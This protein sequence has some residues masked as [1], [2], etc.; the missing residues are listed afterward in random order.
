MSFRRRSTGAVGDEEDYDEDRANDEQQRKPPRRRPSSSFRRASDEDFSN[1]FTLSDAIDSFKLSDATRK[2]IEQM[3]EVAVQNAREQFVKRQST[4]Q[5]VR[6]QS[7]RSVASNS[8]VDIGSSIGSASTA[9]ASKRGSLMSAAS[10]RWMSDDEND[11]TIAEENDDPGDGR[12]TAKKLTLGRRASVDCGA[13]EKK[14][15]DDDVRRMSKS[16]RPSDCYDFSDES[17]ENDEDDDSIVDASNSSLRLGSTAASGGAFARGIDLTSFHE[18]EGGDEEVAHIDGAGVPRATNDDSDRSDRVVK[19]SQLMD[20]LSER[21]ADDGYP[22]DDGL[23][24][25]VIGSIAAPTRRRRAAL[26]P[27]FAVRGGSSQQ[28]Q[29]KPLSSSRSE[30]DPESD[31]RPSREAPPEGGGNLRASIG[32]WFNKAVSHVSEVFAPEVEDAPPPKKQLSG[33]AYFRK[34]QRKAEKCE[35]LKAVALY[36]LALVRQREELDEDH[37]DCATTL[38]EIGVC[39]MMLGERYPAMTAFEEA[40]YIRQ[41]KLGVGAME[42]AETT[43]NIWQVLHEER[44]EDEQMVDL[45]E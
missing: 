27:S 21:E 12:L 26:A 33:R 15:T 39:W 24:D 43:S 11:G 42:T 19:K 8:N 5:L 7:T 13:E 18:G 34:G 17:S 25:E 4:R 10:R 38:N 35:F 30:E 3:D 20:A 1:S 32:G 40:L 41:K 36:N 44:S 14:A 37:V 29:W 2:I 31:R 16:L 45:I 23:L 6:L 9:S 22:A 28:G